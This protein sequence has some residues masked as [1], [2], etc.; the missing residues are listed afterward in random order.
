[1]DQDTIDR[2]KKLE[3][4]LNFLKSIKTQEDYDEG[5]RLHNE[6]NAPWKSGQYTHLTFP[7]YVYKELPRMLYNEQYEDACIQLLEAQAIPA[8]GTEDHERATAIKA[9]EA[10]KQACTVIVKDVPTAERYLSSGDWY[11]SPTAAV[12][13]KRA[14][15]SEKAVQAAHRAWDDRNVGEAAKKE[16]EAFDDA[17]EDF[18]AEIP[19]KPKRG[20]REPV[21]A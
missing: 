5:A 9:A 16:I 17:A 1:M 8:R 15:V 7:T 19:E 18:V 3:E 2:L 4:E 20:K 6:K 12:E 14:K 10:R 13:G 11:L 21:S